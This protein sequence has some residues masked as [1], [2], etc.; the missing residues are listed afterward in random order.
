MT[1]KSRRLLFW[2]VHR[3]PEWLAP[4][5]LGLALRSRARCKP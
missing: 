1:D 2:L 3:S 5:V 4:W